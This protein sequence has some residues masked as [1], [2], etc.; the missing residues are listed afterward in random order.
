MQIRIQ[1]LGEIT[2]TDV[3]FKI[4][5]NNKDTIIK[6][7]DNLIDWLVDRYKIKYDK[8]TT[9]GFSGDDFKIG[10]ETLIISFELK[11]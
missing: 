5:Y 1:T 9:Y 6:R 4:K 10:I 7:V 3:I 8:K 2:Y 11:N